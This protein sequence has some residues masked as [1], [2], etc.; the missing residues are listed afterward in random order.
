MI[1]HEPTVI[2]LGPL[3][4]SGYGLALAASMLLGFLVVA[5]EYRR[6][7]VPAQ[8]LEDIIVVLLVAVLGAKLYDMATG[9]AAL[10]S[11]SGFSMVGGAL[12]SLPTMW[13]LTTRRPVARSHIADAMA[14]GAAAAIPIA[15]SGCWAIGD[16]YGRPFD[17]AWAVAFPHG[18]PPSTV[19]T[20]RT[21]FGESLTGFDGATVLSVHPTQLY[22]L[23]LSFAIFVWLWHR[24]RHAAPWSSFALFLALSAGERFV[25]E[26]VR[27]KTDRTLPGDLTVTQAVTVVLVVLGLMVWWR[28]QPSRRVDSSGGARTP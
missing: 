21:Q 4:L 23:L 9:N 22:E 20:F 1:V 17:G 6:L 16:D 27:A 10:F 13:W 8:A 25:V 19:H 7:G 14:L 3:S 24:R 2:S 5:R 28:A 11:R 26:F 15:R 12:A 18:A